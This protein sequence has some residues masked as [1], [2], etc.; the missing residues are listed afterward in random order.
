M[1]KF[2][3][4]QWAQEEKEVLIESLSTYD[5]KDLMLGSLEP[6]NPLEVKISEGKKLYDIV[7]FQDPFNFSFSEKVHDILTKNGFTGWKSYKIVIKNVD[8]KYYGFQVTGR[9]GP[10]IRPSEPG[11]VKGYKFAHE[12]WD[13]SDFFCPMG[14]L[15]IFCTEKVKQILTLNKITNL[16][17]EDI[18]DIEWY[19][20]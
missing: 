3:S 17:L 20:T 19:S 18:S 16:E 12:T 7:H 2:Y 1:S 13:G 15:N 9:S 8:R 5:D 11:F 10:L 6:I 4:F 14:T